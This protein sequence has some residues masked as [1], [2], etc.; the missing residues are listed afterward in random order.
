MVRIIQRTQRRRL[1]RDR[2]GIAAV[3]FALIA[4]ALIVLFMGVIELTFRFHASQEAT[5][6]VHQAADLIARE[7]GMTT[8]DLDAIYD[9]SV[10][11]MK[12]LDTTSNLDM[13]VLAVALE[14][15]GDGGIDKRVLWRRT[16]GAGVPFDLNDVDGLG[17]V[18]ES[19]VRVGIRYKYTSPISSMF[20]GPDV[21]FVRESFS[22]PRALRY[23]KMDG[24]EDHNGATATFGN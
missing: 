16:A 24:Q 6:Y 7:H 22:R 18:D 12:P 3:E 13:D 9:A 23:I 19:V 20:G 2:K 1:R 11:M 21:H 17:Q 5:R 10:H 4:P 8:N 14:D 15:D